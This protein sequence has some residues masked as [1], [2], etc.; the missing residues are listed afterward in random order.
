MFLAPAPRDRV[1]TLLGTTIH[2]RRQIR[3]EKHSHHLARPTEIA[4][5]SLRPLICFLL[6]ASYFSP[7]LSPPQ[8]K[9]KTKHRDIT[10]TDPRSVFREV[11]TLITDDHPFVKQGI[12]SITRSNGE[13]TTKVAMKSSREPT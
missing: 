5:N 10:M 11:G 8:K 7:L 6:G 9:N 12:E 1:G 13:R 3:E 2:S 4:L